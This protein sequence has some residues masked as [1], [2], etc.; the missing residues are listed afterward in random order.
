MKKIL[1]II[2]LAICTMTMMAEKQNVAVYV[3]GPQPGINKILGDQFV[4][5]FAQSGNY[6]AIERTASFL[7][8]LS[9][10]QSYQEGGAVDNN[11]ITR[12]GKQFGAQL[13]CVVEALDAFGQYYVSARLIAVETAEVVKSSNAYSKLDNLQEVITVASLMAEELA[14][15]AEL[16]EKELAKLK[17]AVEA[18]YMQIGDVYYLVTPLK[19]EFTQSEAEEYAST[20]TYGGLKGWRLPTCQE[21]LMINNEVKKYHAIYPDFPDLETREAKNKLYDTDIQTSFA[22]GYVATIGSSNCTSSQGNSTKTSQSNQDIPKDT[23]KK[24]ALKDTP[25]RINYAHYWCAEKS[26]YLHEGKIHDRGKYSNFFLVRDTSTLIADELALKYELEQQRKDS[27]Q[28]LEQQ[29]KSSLK[30]ALEIG[31]VQIGDIYLLNQIFDYDDY[32]GAVRYANK[33][34]FGGLKGWRLPTCEEAM[35][36]ANKLNEF[37][38]IVSGFIDLHDGWSDHRFE[39]KYWCSETFF[40]LDSSNCK[41]FACERGDRYQFFLV[42]DVNK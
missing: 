21:A 17:K 8:E 19:Q 13:V 26:F 3:T 41:V 7:I 9:K 33:L 34:T 20:F 10:E 36:V 1:T 16:K 11:Q 24:D 23:L 5:S 40:Y 37:D 15:I 38:D 35:M 28:R 22:W 4:K 29:R 2:A 42:R 32:R 31:Y 14:G 12:L 18:G 6:K 30:K 25:P 39:N 27:L